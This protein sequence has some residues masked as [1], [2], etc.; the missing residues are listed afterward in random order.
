MSI[1]RVIPRVY[2]SLKR[3]AVGQIAGVRS[4]SPMK[5]SL[6]CLFL[7]LVSVIAA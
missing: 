1:K 7:T 3:S 2:H 5:G 6:T 4:Y